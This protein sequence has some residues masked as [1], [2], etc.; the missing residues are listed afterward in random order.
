[1]FT[2]SF[3]FKI[4]TDNHIKKSNFLVYFSEILIRYRSWILLTPLLLLVKIMRFL[5]LFQLI[6]FIWCFPTD[7]V[8]MGYRQGSFGE[9][10]EARYLQLRAVS[11]V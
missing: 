7:E 8:P 1:M 2:V 11:V 6:I 3:Y 9:N 5:V 10:T 4:S